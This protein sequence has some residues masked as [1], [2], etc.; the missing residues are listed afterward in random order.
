MLGWRWQIGGDTSP[1]WPNVT[2]LRARRPGEWDEVVEE[3]A[4]QIGNARMVA[5]MN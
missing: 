2:L 4:R 5:A 1:W 3:L